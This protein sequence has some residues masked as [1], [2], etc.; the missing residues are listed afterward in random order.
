MECSA[1]SVVEV[2]L[3]TRGEEYVGRAEVIHS[4]EKSGPLR[5]YGCLFYREDRPLGI[6][7]GGRASAFH[8]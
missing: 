5:Q 7:I 4:D 3:T 6:A 1:G 2:Y 8:A